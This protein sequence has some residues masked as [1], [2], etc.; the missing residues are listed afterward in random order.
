MCFSHG[1]IPSLLLVIK[2]HFTIHEVCPNVIKFF[3]YAKLGENAGYGI[4]KMLIWEKMTNGKVELI[5]DFVCSTITYWGWEQ[6]KEQAGV[7]ASGHAGGQA[8][9]Q[10]M[11]QATQ[12][13][14]LVK[15][16]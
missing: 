13:K 5:S 7:Q 14:R 2:Q 4:D 1:I 16:K 11:V 3:R 10:A 12:V 9:D 15:V 8:S 6:A